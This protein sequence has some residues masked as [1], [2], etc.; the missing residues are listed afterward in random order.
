M[1]GEYLLAGTRAAQ[2]LGH[3]AH[4]VRR[5]AAAEADVADA[6]I[7]R[8]DR[9]VGRLEARAEERV[10]RDRE[11]TRA[12]VVARATGTSAARGVVRYGTGSAATWQS[13]AAR[14]RSMSGSIVS[15]PREQLRPTTSAPAA[16]SRGRPRR[17]RK[18]S[19][20]RSHPCDANVTTAGRPC[21]RITSSP[22]SA[23][24]T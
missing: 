6:G 15:G 24:P 13:T 2:R 17:T 19:I 3:R 21:S 22:I 9:E 5:A 16:S 18:P 23:S 1:S 10:E 11:P 14:T 4:V 8:R 12:V 7:A 20:V